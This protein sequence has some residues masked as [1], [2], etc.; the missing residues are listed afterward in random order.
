MKSTRA[1][2]PFLLLPGRVPALQEFWYWVP[3]RRRQSRQ[4][5]QDGPN[6]NSAIAL[7]P[8]TSLQS[9][10]GLHLYRPGNAFVHKESGHSTNPAQTLQMLL[11][12]P[13][14]IYFLWHCR[15]SWPFHLA[16]SQSSALPCLLHKDCPGLFED[17]RHAAILCH[18]RQCHE[19]NTTQDIFS[20]LNS[21][22]GYKLMTV[23]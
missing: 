13:A 5:C 6:Q 9:H 20:F 1:L 16:L 21:R 14:Q 8:L 22:V 15:L 2:N 12:Y 17:C 7:H 4:I 10:D 11:P 23:V 3:Q 18:P 19:V